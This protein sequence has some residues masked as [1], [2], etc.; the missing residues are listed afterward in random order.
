S[1]TRGGTEIRTFNL[2][3]HLQQNHQVTLATQQS[4]YVTEDEI[5]ALREWVHELVLVPMAKDPTA[6]RLVRPFQQVG[7]FVQSFTAGIPPNVL[8]RYSPDLQAWIDTHVQSGQFDVIT[9]E[10]GVNAVYIRPEFRQRLRT[11][12]NVHSMSYRW[13]LNH[14]QM[15]ASEHAWR[16]RVYLPT[17]YRYEKRH[18]EQFSSIV[19]TTPEDQ[20]ELMT[21][22]PKIPS[23]IIPNGVDLDLFPYRNADPGGYKLVFVGAMDSSHNIDG[24]RFFVTEVMPLLRQQYPEMTLDI[25]GARPS[26][27]ALALGEY[28]GVTVTG[29]V[30]S[31]VNYLHQAVVCVVPL[32]TGFGIKNK[33]LEAMA[34]GVPVV[35][36]DRGL[37]G[38]TVE[39]NGGS[40]YALRANRPEDYVRCISQL[41]EHP[42]LRQQIAERGRSLIEATF[43]WEQAG[44]HYEQVLTEAAPELARI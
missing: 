32:R 27:S 1:P 31:V 10:H 12:L 24:A 5:A 11:V 2:L 35:G 39:G 30:P 34:A 16:D 44:N 7:R 23:H 18:A 25:V 40:L 37:E 8:H 13:T 20:E 4:P 33:T 21:F 28:P 14:L 42:E 6:H 41:V 26:K 38:L 43:T 22:C 15:N 3:R 29:R 17:I 36:S 19:V 9:C